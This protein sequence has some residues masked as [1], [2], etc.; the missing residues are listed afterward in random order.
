MY[1]YTVKY[2]SRNMSNTHEPGDKGERG[3]IK[4]RSTQLQFTTLL[5]SMQQELRPTTLTCFSPLGKPASRDSLAARDVKATS[6]QAVDVLATSS[7]SSERKW[8]I[9]REIPL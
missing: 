1:I 6:N 8:L 5:R 9:A 7:R 2:S 3:S 4:H